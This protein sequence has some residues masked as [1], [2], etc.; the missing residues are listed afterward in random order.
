MMLAQRLQG[1]G[2]S[3]FTKMDN[4][5]KELETA[6]RDLINLSIGS[7]DRAPSL[8][9]RQVLSE[10]VLD[11]SLYG[12]TLSRGTKEFRQ[13]C[14]TWYKK[15]FNVDLDPE[16]EILPLMG[17]QDGLAHIFM[18]YI[19]PGDLAL[20]PDPGY[21]VYSVGL[22]LAGGQRVPLPLLSENGFLPDL[23][24]IKP[25]IARKAKILF[26]NYPNNPT[27]AAASLPFFDEV[28][29]FA[30]EYDILVCHDAAY[31]ELTFA[32]Y[33]PASFLQARNARE[34]G[35]EF[36][37]ISK[38]YNLAGTRLGFVVGKAEVIAALALL[39]ENIDYGVFGP[40]LKAGSAALLGDQ[41]DV[42]EN[43]LA[44]QRRR[45]IWIEGCTEA[46]W[47]VPVPQ[48]TMFVWA[49]VPTKQDSLSFAETLARE[50]G[51][52]VVPGIAFGN[53]G[54]GFVRI[55]LVQNEDKMRESAERVCK[56]LAG[57]V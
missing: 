37:S 56:F 15:R 57:K 53:Y 35:V 45:D 32:G 46:G 3:V 54:E 21:P 25:E 14:C 29:A 50:A 36:H 28:A 40:V 8:Y 7:P 16:K 23:R 48:G 47:S 55:A 6:G 42:K 51:V 5:R 24:A 34:A 1:L 41:E 52:L 12:Y 11:E 20:I 4:L 10:A 44:Y 2:T 26:L 43:C 27:A 49:P 22:H 9:L 38:T 39:K 30:R 18:A 17:S 19:N 33:K 31:S 13:S